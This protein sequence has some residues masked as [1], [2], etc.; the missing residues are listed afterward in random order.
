MCGSP[1]HGA[2]SVP[3][4]LTGRGVRSSVPRRVPW[5]LSLESDPTVREEAALD[6]RG[7]EV[8]ASASDRVAAFEALG[9]ELLGGLPAIEHG[10]LPSPR[11]A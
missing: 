7:D 1:R 10:M 8:R 5:L 9:A 2:K 11:T 3:A 6:P 4:E